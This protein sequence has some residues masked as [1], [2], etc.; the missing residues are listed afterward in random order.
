MATLFEYYNTGYD[1]VA[2][3][4][5]TSWRGQTFTPIVNH[6]I[7]SVKLQMLKG[8]NPGTITVSIRAT[9]AGV[10]VLPDL[11]SGTYDGDTLP[12]SGAGT[13]AEFDF[14]AGTKLKAGTVYGIV[15]RAPDGDAENFL[16]IR[17]DASSPTYTR[18]QWYRNYSSGA[19]GEWEPYER[20]GMFEE[21]GFPLGFNRGHIIG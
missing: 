15:I 16:Y 18:G 17:I 5:G 8:G 19:D 14:G 1:G 12:T 2:Q 3:A 20:D 13:W 11:C 4:Y 7:T 6:T 10:P 9:S 21:W